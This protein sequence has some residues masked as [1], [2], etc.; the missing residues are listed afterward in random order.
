MPKRKIEGTTTWTAS[1]MLPNSVE[2]QLRRIG[3]QLNYLVIAAWTMV[4]VLAI[5]LL[6]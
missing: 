4:A 6:W 2:W 3:N 1:T 5:Y